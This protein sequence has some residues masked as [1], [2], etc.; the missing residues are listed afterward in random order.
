MSRGLKQSQLPARIALQKP[1]QAP[2]RPGSDP[3]LHTQSRHSSQEV[4]RF[5]RGHLSLS[6][7]CPLPFLLSGPA[8]IQIPQELASDGYICSSQGTYRGTPQGTYRGPPQ[9]T[10]RG[11]A[12]ALQAA[13]PRHRQVR[14]LCAGESVHSQPC[15]HPRL[16]LLPAHPWRHAGKRNTQAAA[17]N[18]LHDG[19]Q[20]HLPLPRLFSPGNL[21]LP[22]SP[23]GPQAV[24][25]PPSRGVFTTRPLSWAHSCSAS[26]N[27]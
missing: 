24:R 12:P 9:G 3:S 5:T 4:G 2:C 26:T 19:P 1:S 13:C 18:T 14:G 15:S 10:Y 17:E 16:P 22:L 7:P 25:T 20:K 21:A 8:I 27:W 6:P 11:P 23:W